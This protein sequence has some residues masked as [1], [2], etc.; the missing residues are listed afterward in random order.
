MANSLITFGN[1]ATRAQVMGLKLQA[2]AGDRVVVVVENSSYKIFVNQEFKAEVNGHLAT[3][4][5]IAELFEEAR[6]AFGDF[7]ADAEIKGDGEASFTFYPRN[8]AVS[9]EPQ[10]LDSLY[11]EGKD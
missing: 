5:P 6:N 10:E 7:L 1:L 9:S 3:H 8:I 4:G 11:D 2:K